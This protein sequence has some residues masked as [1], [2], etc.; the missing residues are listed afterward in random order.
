MFSYK[1]IIG[2]STSCL[3]MAHPILSC[4]MASIFSARAITLFI[5]SFSSSV[6]SGPEPDPG[7]LVQLPLWAKHILWLH[8]WQLHDMMISNLTF[9]YTH[10]HFTFNV[11]ANW[12]DRKKNVYRQEQIEHNTYASHIYE[13]TCIHNINTHV[14]FWQIHTMQKGRW[15]RLSRSLST[16]CSLSLCHR[17]HIRGMQVKQ[18]ITD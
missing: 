6:R 2:E 9:A 15:E 5:I 18:R 13:W 14:A 8:C 10:T 3:T 16:Y 17:S 4:S 7:C 11:W 12:A 1:N